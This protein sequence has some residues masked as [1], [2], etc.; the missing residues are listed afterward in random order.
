MQRAKHVKWRVARRCANGARCPARLASLC[1]Q[2]GRLQ[3]ARGVRVRMR[4]LGHGTEFSKH[5]IFLL[6]ADPMKVIERT[7]AVEWW[8]VGA[9]LLLGSCIDRSTKRVVGASGE[10]AAASA[11]H[12]ADSAAEARTVSAPVLHWGS[13]LLRFASSSQAC[14]ALAAET[15]RRLAQIRDP[16]ESS[17]PEQ[18]EGRLARFRALIS[19]HTACVPGS[20]GAWATFFEGGPDPRAWAWFVAFLPTDGPP[21]KH[22]GNFPDQLDERV[23]HAAYSGKAELFDA[24]SYLGP[25]RLQVVSDYD[26]DGTPEAVI[27]TAQIGEELRS[28][29]RGMLWSFAQG[30]VAPYRNTDQL[31]LAPFEVDVSAASEPAPLTDLDGDGRIDLLGYGPFFGVFKQGCGVVES[32]DAVGPRLALHALPDGNFSNRDAAVVAHAKLQ[33]PSRP[34][35]VL[36]FGEQGID[37][38]ATFSTLAC[39]R[40]W[41]VPKSAIESERRVACSDHASSV[42]DCDAKRKCSTEALVVIAAWSK[43]QPAFTLK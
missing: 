29:A 8:L 24:E 26:R 33:C 23:N 7:P 11:P 4:E 39:A 20:G 14:A 16:F 3:W 13:E 17:S 36:A 35:R 12:S 34:T 21:A 25:Y 18:S 1:A 22:A 38:R 2:V 31:S 32:F 9:A 42:S 43:I 40:L 41:N 5:G 30:A 10:R 19:E 15:A 27:W 37:A 28:S 6:V